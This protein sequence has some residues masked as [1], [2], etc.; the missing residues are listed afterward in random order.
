MSDIRRCWIHWKCQPNKLTCQI[1]HSCTMLSTV[2]ARCVDRT[3]LMKAVI[4]PSRNITETSATCIW[5]WFLLSG[6]QKKRHHRKGGTILA[7]IREIN[8][9]FGFGGGG[10]GHTEGVRRITLLLL[11]LHSLWWHQQ[12]QVIVPEIFGH[13][14]VAF[15]T[16]APSN[17]RAPSRQSPDVICFQTVSLGFPLQSKHTNAQN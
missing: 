11:K 3:E 14:L 15:M 1:K 10:S 12:T 2:N 8:K 7:M 16:Y 9:V 17:R 13:W 6:R 4:Y 5:S